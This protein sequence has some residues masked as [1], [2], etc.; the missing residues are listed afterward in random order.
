MTNYS[1]FAFP[2]KIVSSDNSR[3]NNDGFF[4]DDHA[5]LDDE[6]SPGVFELL[7]VMSSN[8]MKSLPGSFLIW[9][10]I[11]YLT[12]ARDFNDAT[13]VKVSQLKDV[14]SMGSHDLDSVLGAVFG[15]RTLAV[16]MQ[17]MNVSFGLPEDGFFFGT[18]YTVWNLV[19]GLGL[20]PKDN[21]SPLIISAIIVVVTA[22]I[23][24][25]ISG[26][27][28]LAVKRISGRMRPETSVI[29]S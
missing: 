17:A 8:I 15:N 11:A 29:R 1:R 6:F 12:N 23:A 18:N 16:K 25:G 28:C 2:V 22:P 5:S 10:P 24:I 19:V 21:F 3:A 20:P 27:V 4:Q 26:V 7:K 13:A 9:R 14:D